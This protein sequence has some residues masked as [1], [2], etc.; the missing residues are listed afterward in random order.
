MQFVRCRLV[1]RFAVAGVES[2]RRALALTGGECQYPKSRSALA[3][4]QLEC[5]MSWAVFAVG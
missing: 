5:Q 2:V 3:L 1:V 4:G